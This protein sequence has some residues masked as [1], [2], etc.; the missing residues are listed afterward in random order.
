[1]GSAECTLIKVNGYRLSVIG[2]KLAALVLCIGALPFVFSAGAYAGEDERK[3]LKDEFTYN[4]QAR[5]QT[6]YL[7]RGLYSGGPNIQASAN[8]GFYG[9]YLD[10]WWNVGFHDMTFKSFQPEVD[11]SLGFNRWGL[12]IYALYIHNFNCGFFDFT[13]YYGKGNRLELNLMYTIPKT[14]LTVRWGTRIAASDCYLN[15]AGEIVRAYSSYAEISWTQPFKDGWSVFG[16]IGVTP[17]K[18]C[19]NPNGAALQ[20]IEVR[21]RK[22]WNIAKHTGLMV[23]GQMAVSPMQA[24]H[25]INLNLALGVFLR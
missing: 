22:D 13:N 16:A 4:A 1:M 3:S 5:I 9:I 7:W 23:Q 21:L 14:R 20:N 12:N 17:W 6:S 2:K 15:A 19:Y 25:V 24:I 10:M 18:G 8:V 11:F